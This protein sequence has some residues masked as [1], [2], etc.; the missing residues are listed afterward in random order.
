MNFKLIISIVVICLIRTIQV[1]GQG[2]QFVVEFA[3]REYLSG[4]YESAVREYQRA[5]LFSFDTTQ[6][7]LHRQIGLCFFSLSD[8]EKAG[9]FL[10]EASQSYATDSLRLECTFGSISSNIQQKR[11]FTALDELSLI[12]ESKTDYF[13]RKKLFYTGICHWGTFHYDEAFNSFYKCVP[14]DQEDKLHRLQALESIFLKPSGPS[15]RLALFLSIIPGIGQMYAGDF[16]SG[17]S[18]M[19]L[20]G[21]L[22]TSGYISVITLKS[23]LLLLY[24]IPWI[25]RYYVGG[26]MNAREIAERHI[27]DRNYK[28]YLE[29]LDIL[30]L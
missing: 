25:K 12:P 23:Y 9:Q 15:P 29:I 6:P 2:L 11:F 4:N 3:D 10:R 5:L 24:M 17:L 20:C 18:S 28:I 19:M 7:Y 1:S 16:R 27:A 13:K 14:E 22:V 8:F 21:F 26:M 30:T